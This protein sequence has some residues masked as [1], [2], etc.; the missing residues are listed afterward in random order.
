ML[1]RPLRRG[2]RPPGRAVSAPSS[3]LS[4]RRRARTRGGCRTRCCAGASPFLLAAAGARAR[5]R[6]RG[7]GAAPPHGRRAGGPAARRERAAARLAAR[8]RGQNTPAAPPRSEHSRP[9]LRRARPRARRAARRRAAREAARAGTGAGEERARAAAARARNARAFNRIIRSS[10]CPESR[11]C[12]GLS[13]RRGG[14]G[15]SAR[16]RRERVSARGDHA[17]ELGSPPPP[18]RSGGGGASAARGSARG[19]LALWLQKGFNE[20]PGPPE[21][22]VCGR[23][24]RPLRVRFA[25][26]YQL[27]V[28]STILMV[29]IKSRLVLF[30]VQVR[31]FAKKCILSR[32]LESS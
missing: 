28:P 16:A 8:R 19:G 27:A 1:A 22:S 2:S 25:G 29:P 10:V 21:A 24:R 12:G 13:S 31:G 18:A 26:W 32:T 3:P 20:Q 6:A 15:R 23:W 14:G 4:C 30:G 11:R 7:A 5:A 17:A 9:R